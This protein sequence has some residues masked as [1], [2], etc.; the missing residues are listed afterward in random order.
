MFRSLQPLYV[1]MVFTSVRLILFT[2]TGA[3]GANESLSTISVTGKSADHSLPAISISPSAVRRHVPSGLPVDDAWSLLIHQVWQS[4]YHHLLFNLLH[5]AADACTSGY[6][7]DCDISY[8][9][10][11]LHK[12]L[13]RRGV[14]CWLI[15]TCRRRVY[16]PPI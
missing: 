8:L 13:V 3:Q 12:L 2:P 10:K 6:F 4:H 7:L 9:F 14:N 1:T 16:K 15:P 5:D 11:I